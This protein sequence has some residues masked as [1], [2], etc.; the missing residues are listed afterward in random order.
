MPLYA[1]SRINHL[2]ER[3]GTR[4]LEFDDDQAAVDFARREHRDYPLEVLFGA[5]SLAVLPTEPWRI[6]DWLLR[7]IA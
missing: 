7:V 2:G 6:E 5:Q 1:I 3:F 4:M